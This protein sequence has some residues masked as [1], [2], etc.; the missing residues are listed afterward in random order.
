MVT[1]PNVEGTND[2]TN[3][4]RGSGTPPWLYHAGPTMVARAWLKPS[5][6]QL[7]DSRR[8][9]AS[10]WCFSFVSATLWGMNG[11]ITPP[12]APKGVYLCLG[13][14][15]G[16]LHLALHDIFLG[17]EGNLVSI[18]SA[19]SRFSWCTALPCRHHISHV[20]TPNNTNSVSWLYGTK[21]SPTLVFI[22]FFENEN[23]ISKS[24]LENN[25]LWFRT[26]CA[27]GIP[28]VISPSSLIRIG[29][30]TYPNQRYRRCPQL[31]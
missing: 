25:V 11:L 6:R 3:S 9:S 28:R 27:A 4:S 30:S 19:S 1:S 12:W 15:W 23:N 10:S 18:K 20:R 7:E 13:E 24:A 14:P 21:C 2:L 29:P 22:S 8:P 5:P 17:R 26:Y 31:W 16:V